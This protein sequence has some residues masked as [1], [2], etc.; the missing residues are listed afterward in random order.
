VRI[1]K[2]L[3]NFAFLIGWGLIVAAWID[4]ALCT[5]VRIAGQRRRIQLRHARQAATPAQL[6]NSAA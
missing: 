1:L 4:L 3:E 6:L 2:Y 5:Y